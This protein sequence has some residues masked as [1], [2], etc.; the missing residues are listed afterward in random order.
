[1]FFRMIVSSALL[2]GLVAGL[3]LTAGQQLG[4]VPII[5]AAEKYEIADESTAV[6]AED[7]GHANDGHH[8]DAAAW[9]PSDGWE[10]TFYTFV[11]N[12]F[13]AVGFSAVLMALMC[14]L[15]L[16]GLTRLTPKKGML[17][18]VAG[19][20]CVF[21]APGIGLPPEIPGVEAAAVKS[22][23]AW[24]FMAVLSSAVGVGVLLLTPSWYRLIGL[25]FLAA[26]YIFGAPHSAGPLFSHPDPNA[27]AALSELHIQFIIASGITNL[28]FWLVLGG[29]CA[30]AIRSFGLIPE[31][32]S[33]A[34]EQH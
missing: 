22:R 30:Y 17:W 11:A 8:H 13:A 21:V 14:Q 9:A 31:N 4:V 15:Q 29:A 23:Q 10:R 19:F 27:V 24:W 26:P 18:G 3:L 16:F 2:I 12:V 25:V 34:I 33:D 20:V 32:R 5:L 28:L 7:H 1:M 6:S